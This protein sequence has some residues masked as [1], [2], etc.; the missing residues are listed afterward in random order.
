M[1]ANRRCLFPRARLAH[2]E[3]W[4]QSS[5]ESVIDHG[6]DGENGTTSTRGHGDP[7][8]LFSQHEGLPWLRGNR[9]SRIDRIAAPWQEQSEPEKQSQ[10]ELTHSR[11]FSLS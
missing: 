7:E 1:G 3:D 5:V 8:L 2:E 4:S 11:L 9:A 6:V 10:I